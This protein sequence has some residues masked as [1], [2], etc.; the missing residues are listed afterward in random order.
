MKKAAIFGIT[1]FYLLLTTGMFVCMVHCAAKN[2]VTKPGMQMAGSNA[3]QDNHC[4]GGK[5]C[6]CCKKHGS[7]VVKENLK[8]GNNIQFTQTPVLIPH[9]QIADFLLNTPVYHNTLRANNNAPPGKSGK[10]ISIQFCSL[11]I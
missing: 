6:D 7:Y 5:D 3:H 2:L 8:P 10:A 1:A 9:I 11:L 4:K